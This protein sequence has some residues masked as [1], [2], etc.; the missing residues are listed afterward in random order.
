MIYQCYFKKEHEKHIFQTDC[1]QGFGLE[2]EVNSEL[3]INCPEL[4]DAKTRLALAEYAC[5]LWF[6]RNLDC[7]QGDY[8]G[9]TSYRQL[10]KQ[11]TIF[12]SQSY[13]D[14]IKDPEKIVTWGMSELLDGGGFPLPISI[15]TEIA[16]PGMTSYINTV[17]DEVPE[18]WYSS[19]KV[20]FGNYWY[21][22]KNF[23]VDFMDFSWPLVQQSLKD[24]K[25]PY[26]SQEH[27]FGADRKKAVGY[28]MERLFILWSLKKKH[29]IVVANPVTPLRSPV[30]L[31]L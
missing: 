11:P 7:I 20:V 27:N 24:Q 15:Q 26:F 10:D 18:G 1:Y 12:E 2:P 19:N 29:P 21:M 5:F 14:S 8:F 25:H 22:H 13:L 9:T 3:F 6:Y 31:Y 16:H 23:F 17:V 4:E 30:R 28:F